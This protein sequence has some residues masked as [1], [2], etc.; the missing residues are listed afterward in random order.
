M[1]QHHADTINK[2][3][4]RMKA[5]DSVLALIIAGSVAHGFAQADADVDIM[6][7]VSGREYR[8]RHRE[9]RE[10]YRDRE[11]ATY[12][13][14][15]VDGKYVSRSFI[16]DVIRHGGEPARFAFQ[17]AVVAF[18]RRPGLE[19]LLRKAARYPKEFK[20]ARMRRLYSRF[21]EWAWLYAE[22]LKKG[23]PYLVHTAIGN[24]VLFG[25]RA[26]LA[27][28]ERLY[29]FHKWYLKVLEGAPEKPAG[30]MEL[31]DTALNTG[32]AAAVERLI[33]AVKGFRDWG[34]ADA[35]WSDCLMAGEDI[36]CQE[37]EL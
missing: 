22:G 16:R 27:A 11:D 25:G 35:E 23:N 29:P 7:L 19:T 9:K 17:D 28:N 13:G 4:K 24:I 33:A 5:D 18:S 31:I 14:G 15:C 37:S 2:V 20:E 6:I 34:I 1:F 12:E 3:C 8:K 26:V 32:T 21:L 30:L 36:G 10:V